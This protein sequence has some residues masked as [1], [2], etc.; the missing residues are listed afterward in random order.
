MKQR[1]ILEARHLGKIYLRDSGEVVHAL[2]DVD[3][4]VREGDFAALFG[5]PGAGKTTLL[6]ILGLMEAA[7]AGR[8]WIGGHRAPPA[9]RAETGGLQ[10]GQ[11]GLVD[12]VTDLLPALTVAE[13]V[14]LADASPPERGSRWERTWQLVRQVGLASHWGDLV[15]NVSAEG[16]YRVALARALVNQPQVLLVDLADL[17]PAGS[18][19]MLVLLKRLNGEGQTILYATRCPDAASVARTLYMLTAGTLT[20]PCTG[21]AWQ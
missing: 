5:A 20:T 4:S 9:C 2:S 19:A 6:R 7:T 13:N 14:V 3:L 15:R 21:E 18:R 16:Q 17:S 12:G 1:T 11:V 10:A 8:I